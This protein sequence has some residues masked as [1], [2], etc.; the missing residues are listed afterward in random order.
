MSTDER[1]SS[2]DLIREARRRLDTP[3]V[4]PEGEPFVIEPESPL[5]E[6][7]KPAESPEEIVYRSQIEERASAEPEERVQPDDFAPGPSESGA[8]R[9]LT[10]AAIVLALGAGLFLRGLGDA[11]RDDSGEIVGAGDLDVMDLQV[12]DCFNDPEEFEELVFEVAAVPCAE[13]HDNEVFAVVSVAGVFSAFPGT[14]V[15]DEYSYDLCSGDLFDSYVGTT[16]LES[17]LEVFSFTPTQESWDQGDR[18][19]TCILFRWDFAK[20]SGSARNSGL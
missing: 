20:L 8:K 11:S 1:K 5:L 12:G 16:Y 6:S 10:W 15:L 17:E 14:P 2:D 9:W 18:E 19:F 4:E 7:S 13:A 3:S